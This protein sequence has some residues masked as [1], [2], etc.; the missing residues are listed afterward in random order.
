MFEKN[1]ECSLSRFECFK[2]AKEF[3]FVSNFEH[4]MCA[5]NGIYSKTIYENLNYYASL[6]IF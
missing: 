2:H 5:I 1:K 4:V 3:R 6:A